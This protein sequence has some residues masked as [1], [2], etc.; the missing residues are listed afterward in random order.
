[1]NVDVRVQ[2]GDFSVAAE[3]QALRQRMA[4]GMGAVASFVGFV[5]DQFQTDAV[6]TLYLE[7][8]PGMT[9]R[10]IAGIVATAAQR[11]ALMDVVVVHRVGAL[12]PSAQ[13][14]LVQVVSAHR[15]TAFAACEFIMDY[16]KTEAIFW[17]REDTAAG[18]RWVQS[19]LEDR[20]RA[21]AWTKE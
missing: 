21:A 12:H 11:W 16:L 5:R 15:A 3:Y 17:K 19:T 1:M 8:Y 7:H 2:T 4:G 9:E 13:I 6:D 14:V 20:D 10:S 18:G